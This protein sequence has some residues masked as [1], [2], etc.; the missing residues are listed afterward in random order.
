MWP[1]GSIW[2]TKINNTF[3]VRLLQLDEEMQSIVFLKS[4]WKF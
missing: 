1:E 2:N 3:L 4:P